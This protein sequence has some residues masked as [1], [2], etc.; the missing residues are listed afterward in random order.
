MN[1]AENDCLSSDCL[2]KESK[3]LT[4]PFRHAPEIRM[5]SVYPI[6]SLRSQQ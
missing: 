1:P 5:C 2:P 6:G 4:L 3:S